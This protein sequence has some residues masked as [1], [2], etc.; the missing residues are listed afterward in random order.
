[1]NGRRA[2]DGLYNSSVVGK[3][4]YNADGRSAHTVG[5]VRADN[6]IAQCGGQIWDRRIHRNQ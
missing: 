6:V 2:G 4:L 3:V 5:D 1:M